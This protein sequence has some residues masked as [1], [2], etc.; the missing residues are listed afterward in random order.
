M[1]MRKE[2]GRRNKEE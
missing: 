1:N 2:T